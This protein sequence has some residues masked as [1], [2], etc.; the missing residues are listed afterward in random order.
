MTKVMN[1]W[2][3]ARRATVC[4]L[5]LVFAGFSP[6]SGLQAQVQEQEPESQ[7]ERPA[8]PPAPA[9]V[10]ATTAAESLKQGSPAEALYLQLRTVGLDPAR[11][12]RIRGASFERAAIHFSLDDGT[13]AFTRDV[14]GRVTGAFFEGDGEVLLSPPNQAERASMALFTGAAI[15]EE[16]FETAYFRF[17]DDTF[18]ELQPWLR[19]ADEPEA[20][21][22]Q[23][24]E[25]ARNLAE[26]DSLRLLLS[27][28]QLLPVAGEPAAANAEISKDD[29]MMHARVRGRK[30][31]TFDLYFDSYS[32]E[33]VWAGQLKT[34]NGD[35]YYDVW[36]SF[37]PQAPSGRAAALSMA[38]GEAGGNNDLTISDYRIRA[39][40]SPPTTLKA[41][42]SLDLEVQQGGQRAV[43]FELSRFLQ[44]QR[45]EADG[46]P[47]EFIHNP[48]IQ[49]TQLAQ[50]G[51][52]LVAV[53]FPKPLKSGDRL[54][55]HF[56]YGGDVLSE[57]GGGLL[58]VGARGIWYPN[59]GL[60]MARFDLEF[61]YPAGWTLVATGKRVE[62]T[63]PAPGSEQISHWIS[64]KPIPVAG[65]NLGKYERAIAKAGNV[66]VETYAATGVEHTFPK[67][68]TI[69]E[70][71]DPMI[72]SALRPQQPG[73][74]VSTPPTP[75]PAR[76]AQAVADI[77][78]RAI[79][80]FSSRFGPYPY[81]SL[82][83]TQM[84]GAISQGWPGLVFLSSFSF[85]TKA[86]KSDLHM[87][88]V[89]RTLTETVIAHETAHQWW[90]D[91][92]MWGSYRDQWII[93]GL[94]NYS[95]L[96][97]LE[98]SDPQK[99]HAVLDK[100]RD[101]L[102]HKNKEGVPLMDGGPVSL[103]TRLS[104]SQFPAGYEAISYG[105]GTW[106]FHM[107]RMMMRDAAPKSAAGT[108]R[109]PFIRALQ[110]ISSQYA[111][112]VITTRDLLRGFEEELP[113]SL[114]YEGKLSL[115][116][117]YDGWVNG[118]A[119]PRFEL[120][121]VKYGSVKS[122]GRKGLTLVS[123][124]IL[125]KD[126]P[127]S[128]VTSVPLYGI[129]AGKQVLLGRVFADGPATPFRFSA[130]EG[131]R[132]LVIDPYQTVLARVQ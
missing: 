92:V 117:F 30:L 115:D 65:F 21:A 76:N 90:G 15:L 82:A 97:L 55:L 75:S 27:F 13:I 10:V 57:A 41:D 23:W 52:D 111:G 89:T 119:I 11:V 6:G 105:R 36:T 7:A 73:V 20:F 33:Q 24:D 87:D 114:D 16:R 61:R 85:L 95:A 78:A 32:S 81:G 112:R 40:V 46:Q 8:Q 53:I 38:T 93:E 130:P 14:Y 17:N 9:S 125:Q 68:S 83:L 109:E 107:L 79:D 77:S 101:D 26:Q 80:F 102:L 128:L 18:R 113:K 39:E 62:N 96:M 45:I 67:A 120:K 22:R 66:T 64:E 43:L 126:A 99:F 116:W 129:A 42:A 94:A 4:L 123:G 71:T 84:P 110:K 31:G 49:G 5:L 106:L 3:R 60:A 54:Q 74:I 132:K 131:T 28:S 98:S 91:E 104:C 47:A 48:S 122:G 103:G 1:G 124:T 70:S 69:V 63:S 56:V 121:D 118:I 100:Y 2:A 59:R 29:R 51:N 19:A 88:A 12:F 72:P 86:E 37:S 44:I 35:V 50:R 34:V 108:A 58:Y 25:T 127:D